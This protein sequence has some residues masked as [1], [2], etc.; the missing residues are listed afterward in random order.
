MAHAR[1]HSKMAV[2]W[3]FCSI[4]RRAGVGEGTQLGRGGSR[5]RGKGTGRTAPTAVD[6]ASHY[7][8]IKRG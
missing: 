5:E 3:K 1:D 8:Q 6:G 2:Q 4:E 7:S